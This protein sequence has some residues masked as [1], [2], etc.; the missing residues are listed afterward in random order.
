MVDLFTFWVFS[1][2]NFCRRYLFSSG[3][4]LSNYPNN[5]FLIFAY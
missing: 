1:G 2:F 4:I 5:L 3:A